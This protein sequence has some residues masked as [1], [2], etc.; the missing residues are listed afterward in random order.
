[1]AKL[2]CPVIKSQRKQLSNLL[3]P[4]ES[5]HVNN[6]FNSIKSGNLMLKSFWDGICT[7]CTIDFKNTTPAVGKSDLFFN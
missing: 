6:K 1:M 2:Y 5:N 3:M 7:G 4:M